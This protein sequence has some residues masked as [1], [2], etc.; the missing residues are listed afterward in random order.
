MLLEKIGDD[1]L[2]HLADC[3]EDDK[4]QPDKPLFYDR[5]ARTIALSGPEA[6]LIIPEDVAKEQERYLFTTV[7]EVL[8]RFHERTSAR[9]NG[10]KPSEYYL[11]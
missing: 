3:V 1:E 5:N 2:K 6:L 7:G 9:E 10:K 11:G 8:A 4:A